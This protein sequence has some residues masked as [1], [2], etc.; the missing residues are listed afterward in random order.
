MSAP[1]GFSAASLLAAVE[2]CR[3]RK[4]GVFPTATEVRDEAGGGDNV[5]AAYAITTAQIR[6]GLNLHKFDK[7]PADFRDLIQPAVGGTVLRPAFDVDLAG[8][9]ASA[10]KEAINIMLSAISFAFDEGTRHAKE[11]VAKAE[12][13]VAVM[14]DRMLQMAR[15]VDVQE[16]A[17]SQ[18]DA[19]HVADK[20]GLKVD[21]GKLETRLEARDASVARQA[22]EIEA[23]KT[24]V[25]QQRAK[26][27]L[28]EIE[29]ATLRGT[30]QADDK[31]QVGGEVPQTPSRRD[32]AVVSNAE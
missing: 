31:A 3:R 32:Q 16:Q 17:A 28:A 5:R 20:T 29:L 14:H 30:Y 11:A 23:L 8:R 19:S 4:E 18:A 1:T 22:V 24:E 9:F 7:L 10:V 15:Q 13:E 6:L 12:N 27:R 2:A 21:I 25:E 26:L